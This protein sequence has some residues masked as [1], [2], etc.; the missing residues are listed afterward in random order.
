[1]MRHQAY[2][3]HLIYDP[4]SCFNSDTPPTRLYT[5]MHTGDWWW[6]TQVRRDTPG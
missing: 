2:A 5:E 4:Q 1:L 6:E 3:E